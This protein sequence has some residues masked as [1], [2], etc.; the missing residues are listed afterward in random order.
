MIFPILCAEDVAG[1]PVILPG[2]LAGERSVVLIAFLQHQ[3]AAVESWLPLLELLTYRLGDF[4]YY[5]IP[6]V[7]RLVGWQGEFADMGVRLRR[8]GQAS[9]HLLT[10]YVDLNDFNRALDIPTVSQIYPLLIDRAGH[11]LWRA[12]GGFTPEK[13]ERLIASLEESPALALP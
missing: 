3:Q 6:T 9:E 11:V 1:Q 12:E 7:Q 4:H 5:V 2:D 8:S 13:A 10:L